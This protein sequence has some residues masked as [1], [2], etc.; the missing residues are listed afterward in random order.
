MTTEIAETETE[1]SIDAY[2]VALVETGNYI[3]DE[4]DRPHIR[5]IRGV[6]LFDRNVHVHCCEL[7]PSYYL[8]HL[9]DQVIPADDA[10]DDVLERLDETY[11]HCGGEDCYVHVHEIENIIKAA[12]P[13]T[14]HQYGDPGV[15]F[16]D[17]ERDKQMES[18]REHF[19][20]NCP[21]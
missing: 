13:W 18:L 17:V 16:D 11:G 4:S 2:C 12:R 9:Y 7:T 6:Y 20:G 21:F 14:V 10:P 8:I 19:N 3:I 1:V 5:E 15:S